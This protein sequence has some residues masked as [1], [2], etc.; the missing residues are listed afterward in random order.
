[1]FGERGD[2]QKEE[3]TAVDHQKYA[4]TRGCKQLCSYIVRSDS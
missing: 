4:R 2:G 3:G 1:M